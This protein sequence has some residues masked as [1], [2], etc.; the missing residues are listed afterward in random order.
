[1]REKSG[2][3]KFVKICKKLFV[4]LSV[5]VIAALMILLVFAVQ[6][7]IGPMIIAGV[8]LVGYLV[9]YGFYAMRISMGTVIGVEITDKVVH[10]KTKRRTF[11]Y[12]VKMGCVGVKVKKNKFICTFQTQ[13]SRDSFTFYRRVLFS[14]YGEEQFT[15][16]EI[17]AFYPSF[18][19]AYMN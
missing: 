16:Q 19:F 6:G 7:F 1:M 12:D 3:L 14:P 8:L 10:V 17:A 11:T 15:P 4:A 9:L 13:D 18:D 2:I 5:F